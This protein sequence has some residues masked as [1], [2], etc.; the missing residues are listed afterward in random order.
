MQTKLS[1]LLASRFNRSM[2]FLPTPRSVA[3]ILTLALTALA[4]ASLSPCPARAQ[5]SLPHYNVHDL[6]TL[7][8]KTTTAYA[9]NMLQQ[10]VGISATAG[11]QEHAFL[12]SS[13]SMRDLG[14]LGGPLS[15]ATSINNYGQ[16]AGFSMNSSGQTRGFRWDSRNGMIDIST[17][18]G[19]S[20]LATGISDSGFIVG[21]SATAQNQFHA[22]LRNPNSGR[23]Q[24]LGTL[25][26]TWSMATAVYDGNFGLTVVGVSYTANDPMLHGFIWTPQMGT[27][28]D[29]YYFQ[30]HSIDYVGNMVG[31]YYNQGWWGVHT[32]GEVWWLGNLRQMSKQLNPYPG[33]PDC[34]AFAGDGSD[35]V[36]TSGVGGQGRPVLWIYGGNAIDLNACISANSGWVLTYPVGV[37]WS[38]TRVAGNGIHNGLN[39]AF[40]LSR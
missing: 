3:A 23:M 6:G 25:G 37:A 4:L 26:G 30:P 18:G 20:T 38:G 2:T 31:T 34:I 36:G 5:S 12:W 16:V 21:G 32:W 14:T 39:R 15:Q 19:P 9:I 35:Y 13:G 11:N 27:L 40:L 33:D 29:T 22:F 28:H 1:N 8:G 17:L 10:I 24:D 7:G